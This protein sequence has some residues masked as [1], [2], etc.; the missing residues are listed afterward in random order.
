MMTSTRPFDVSVMKDLLICPIS[1]ALLEDPVVD[2]CG[3]TFEREMIVT[4][5]QQH[6]TCPLARNH[7]LRVTELKTNYVVKDILEVLARHNSDPSTLDEEEQS[8]VHTGLE[9]IIHQ[10]S[11]DADQGIPDRVPEDERL[12]SRVERVAAAWAQCKHETY[13]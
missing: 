6:T 9:Q 2:T 10:R 13:C 8:I 5:L 4:W 1:Y 3:H 11:V 12:T 7:T